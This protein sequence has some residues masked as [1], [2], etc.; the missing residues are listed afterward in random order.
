MEQKQ[1]TV[2][3]GV[4]D[5]VIKVAMQV[6]GESIM[7]YLGQGGKV[8]R[9]GP[10]E[11]IHLEAKQM[12]ED[13]NFE[14]AG[15]YWRHYEFESDRISV[16]DMRRFREYEAFLSMTYQMPVITTVLCSAKM[17]KARR[18]IKEGINTYHVEVVQLKKKDAD[19]V[20]SKIWDM[21]R[22]GEK[23]GKDDLIPVLLTP[24]MSGK[25]K[26]YE[27]IRQGFQILREVQKDMEEQE[28]KKMQ[29]ILYTFAYKFL[30]ND[31]LEK[32]KEETSMTALGRMLMEDGIKEGRKRGES[33]FGQLMNCL[34]FDNRI[35]DAK[36]AAKDAEARK[37]FYQEYGISD[38]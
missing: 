35:E 13:F 28:A 7:K 21:L 34:F 29:A 36:L 12:Y 15:G 10:T 18:K 16:K 22:S 4:E 17:K 27:R 8:K 23:I 19:K 14:M 37:R 6:F 20:L 11:H 26:I 38:K 33:L 31:E 5:K 32:I 24:L 3:T 25:S 9:I 2:V 30:D 1:E